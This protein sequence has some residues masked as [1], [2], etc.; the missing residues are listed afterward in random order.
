VVAHGFELADGVVSRFLRVE[1]GEVVPTGIVVDAVGRG[2]VPD[3]DEQC[4]TLALRGPRRVAI[5]RYLAAREVSR[6]WEIDI[7]AVPRAPC[8]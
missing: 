5:R 7:A 4:A 6:V 8:R 2:D 3:R 1:L